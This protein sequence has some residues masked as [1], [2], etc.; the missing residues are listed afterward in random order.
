[1]KNVDIEQELLSIKAVAYKFSVSSQTVV[2]WIKE[3]ELSVVRIGLGHPRI[4]RKSVS[5]MIE[6]NLKTVN[7][8]GQ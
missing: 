5:D 1:M 2:R 8:V 6:R 3:G 4:P 7:A